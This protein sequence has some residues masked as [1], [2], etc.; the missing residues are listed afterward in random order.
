[1]STLVM[2]ELQIVQRAGDGHIVENYNIPHDFIQDS[3]VENCGRKIKRSNKER[4]KRKLEKY[5]GPV[6]TYY[7]SV[8]P[9]RKCLLT[10]S[11]NALGLVA[12]WLQGSGRV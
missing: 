5:V 11:C 8:H 6:L 12:D 1:M 3:V 7:A 10:Y 4:R 2:R 9:R